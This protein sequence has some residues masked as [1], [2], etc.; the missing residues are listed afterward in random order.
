MNLGLWSVLVSVQY[1][2]LFKSFTN[3]QK[4]HEIKKNFAFAKKTRN[5]KNLKIKL[6]EKGVKLKCS[7]KGPYFTILC[8]FLQQNLIVEIYFYLSAITSQNK[9][10]LIKL[11]FNLLLGTRLLFLIM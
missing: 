8:Y 5:T 11:I 2:L 4:N 6:Q 9:I 1:P 3:L 7:R 10:V